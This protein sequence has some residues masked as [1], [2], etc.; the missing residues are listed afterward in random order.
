MFLGR[1]IKIM[2]LGSLFIAV[3]PSLSR[4]SETDATSL[5]NQGNAAYRNK[6]W[7]DAIDKY[8]DAVNSGA[9]SP[10]L[11]YNL[12]CAYFR[13]GDIGRAIL[14]FERARMLKPRDSDINKNLAFTRKLTQDKV[15]SVYRNTLLVWFWR[16]MESISFSELW[17]LLLIISL[18]A[19]IAVSYSILQLRAYWIGIVLWIV[20]LIFAGAWYVKGNRLWERHLGITVAPKVDVRSAPSAEGE[21]LFTI[22]SGTRVGIIERRH[23]WFRIAIEDGHTG[24]VDETAIEPVIMSK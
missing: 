6:N 9:M 3:L 15:E 16:A 22:H 12:G 19:T 20:F 13:T 23:D 24:W 4:G 1:Y 17:W 18:V 8:L 2:I 21:I 5:Y 11:F 14:W 10:E 7:D